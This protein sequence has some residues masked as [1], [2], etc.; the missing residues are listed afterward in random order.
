MRMRT[1]K[2]FGTI[3]LLLFLA[4]YSL[5]AMAVGVGILPD[6]NGLAQLLYYAVAGLAWVPPAGLL[7]RWMSRPDPDEISDPQVRTN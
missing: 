6:A 1:R 4:I 3:G 7:I 2:F 5:V